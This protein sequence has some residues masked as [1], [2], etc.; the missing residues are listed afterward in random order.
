VLKN[1]QL[2]TGIVLFLSI[3]FSLYGVNYLYP[4]L[5]QQIQGLTPTQSGM[6]LLPNGLATAVSI[7]F[8]GVITSNPKSKVDPRM[9]ILIGIV[10]STLSLLKLGSLATNSGQ[11]DTFFPLLLRGLSLGFLFIPVNSV[12]IT[13]LGPD[14]VQEGASLLG[15]ARQLGGSLGTALLAT[16]F[17]A[18][19]T[20]VRANLIGYVND[21]SEAYQSTAAQMSGALLAHGYNAVQASVGANGLISRIVSTQSAM[22]SYNHTFLLIMMIGLVTTPLVFLL[23]RPKPGVATAAI[24]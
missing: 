22:V 24:H 6:S 3:G 2:T 9:L 12:S 8:C 23:Q 5:A 10:L 1:R 16:Y 14:D 19:N 20:T 15:L 4:L 18:E 11:V 13:S 21:R 7:V 17:S